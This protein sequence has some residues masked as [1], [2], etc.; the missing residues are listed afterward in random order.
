MR[1]EHGSKA[2][3]MERFLEEFKKAYEADGFMVALWLV[4]GDELQLTCCTTHAFPL[5]NR[6][7]CEQQLREVNQAD[8]RAAMS[9]PPPLPVTKEFD[10]FRESMNEMGPLCS[11]S[12]VSI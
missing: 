8:A 12:L 7:I 3:A 9:P 4:R 10:S 2:E 11:I 5:E 1:V 6:P